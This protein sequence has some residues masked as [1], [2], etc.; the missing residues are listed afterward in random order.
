MELLKFLNFSITNS[1][2][3]VRKAKVIS[4]LKNSA[5]VCETMIKI[6]AA[7]KAINY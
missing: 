2:A 7:F 1:K 5:G 6:N 4:S 3:K